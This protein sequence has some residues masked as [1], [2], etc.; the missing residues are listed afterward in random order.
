MFLVGTDYLCMFVCVYECMYMFVKH[1]VRVTFTINFVYYRLKFVV[2]YKY[3][4]LK[5]FS[6]HGSLMEDFKTLY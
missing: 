2:R 1:D 5:L 3:I 6:F 4:A